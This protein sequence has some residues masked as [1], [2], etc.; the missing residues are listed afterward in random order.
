MTYTVGSL[1]TGGAAGIDLA[2]SLTGYDILW[3]VE[4]DEFCRGLLT[5]NERYWPNAT[6][7]VDVRGVTGRTGK[8][9]KGYNLLP[10]VDVL[11]GG[12]PCTD[13]SVAGKRAGIREGTRSGLWTEFLRLIGELRPRVVLLENVAGI[14]Y[15]NA[16]EVGHLRQAD[17]LL[18]VGAL[19][20]IGYDAGWQ[21]ISAADAG[22]PHLRKRWFCM[23]VPQR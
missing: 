11:I 17:G 1:F 18:V 14:T 19:A 5:K 20:E 23:A 22:A 4:I 6:Q 12:F 21:I 10:R 3:Q 7:Y 2:F 15:Q 9:W 8:G 16:Q 13:I